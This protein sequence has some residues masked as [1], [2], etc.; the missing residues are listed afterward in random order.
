MRWGTASQEVERTSDVPDRYCSKEAHTS[1]RQNAP[2]SVIQ[3]VCV[4]R[5]ILDRGFKG[6][7]RWRE[8][9]C[10]DQDLA[11]VQEYRCRAEVVW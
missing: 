9:A 7:H 6:Q 4:V 10:R 11:Q 5:P 2:P 1:G 8:R 3:L